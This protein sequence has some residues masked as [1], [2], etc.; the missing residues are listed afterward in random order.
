FSAPNMAGI[1]W[2]NLGDGTA[3]QGENEAEGGLMDGELK[4]KPAYDALNRLIN[5]E[6]KTSLAAQTDKQGT[7]SFRGFYG[8]YTV[9]VTAG[10][11][12]REFFVELTK[13]GPT[14]HRLIWTEPVE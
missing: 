12:A 8:R 13:G 10:G 2:W 3:V 1:T 14:D 5:H 7:V 9:K 11:Q 4:P 6:W